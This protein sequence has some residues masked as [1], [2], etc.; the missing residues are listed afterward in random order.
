MHRITA[1]IAALA[2]AA[3]LVPAALADQ[4]TR[5]PLPAGTFTISGSCRFDVQAEPVANK[6]FV[7]IL[8]S[9]KVIITGQLMYRLTSPYKSIVVNI[10]GPGFTTTTSPNFELSGASLLFYPGHLLLTRGPVLLTFDAIGNITSVTQ[11][12]AAA[13]DLCAVLADP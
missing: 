9:G 2:S 8:D 3:L 13:T 4:P 5:F 1:V 6:E 10:S 7:T 11:T 12:S